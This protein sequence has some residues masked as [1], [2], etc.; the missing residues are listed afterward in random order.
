MTADCG[1]L[2]LEIVALPAATCPPV[3]RVFGAMFN[4]PA[5]ATSKARRDI[6]KRHD[7]RAVFL[8]TINSE[9]KTFEAD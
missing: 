3:G 4:P 1:V 8:S 5:I 9:Y 2:A 7:C 6:R